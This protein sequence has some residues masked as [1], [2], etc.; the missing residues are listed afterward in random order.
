MEKRK[1]KVKQLYRARNQ[2]KNSGYNSGRIRSV[3]EDRKG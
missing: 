2:Y 1:G 3:E